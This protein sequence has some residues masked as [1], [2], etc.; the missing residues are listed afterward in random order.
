MQ[1]LANI[2]VSSGAMPERWISTLDGVHEQLL[3]GRVEQPLA[4]LI[5]DLS[6]RRENDPESWPAYAQFCLSHPVC[7]L[8]YEDPFT[9]RA[10]AKPRGY[11]GDAVMMDYIYG[12][13]EVAAAAR[14]ACVASPKP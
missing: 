5:D 8:L 11:A 3:A 6:E 7:R 9:H 4:E 1:N 14:A 10:F 12:L 2:T 13:G